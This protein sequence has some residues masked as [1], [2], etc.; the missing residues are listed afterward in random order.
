M[1]SNVRFISGEPVKVQDSTGFLD[2][3]IEG[4]DIHYVTA[5]DSHGNKAEAS[6]FD[7]ETAED[8]A[9]FKLAGKRD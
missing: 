4:P 3:L 6:A 2:K 5:T 7:R 1:G 9:I 8:R